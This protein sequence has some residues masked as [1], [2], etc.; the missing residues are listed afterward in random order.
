MSTPE[1]R[2]E[3]SLWTPASERVK[4]PRAYNAAHVVASDQPRPARA[5]SGREPLHRFLPAARAH[6][7]RAGEK[8]EH[9]LRRIADPARRNRAHAHARTQDRADG[10]AHRFLSLHAR[11][12]G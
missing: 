7:R 1:S 6:P 8:R 2:Y 10:T 5:S 3:S 9:R 4:E 11:P 12:E